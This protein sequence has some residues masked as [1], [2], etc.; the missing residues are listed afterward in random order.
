[1]LVR[2]ARPFLKQADRM[3]TALQRGAERLLALQRSDDSWYGS[4]RRYVGSSH[5]A[6][7]T[8]GVAGIGLAEAYRIT[9]DPSCL[10]GARRAASFASAHLGSGATHQAHHPRFTA[11]DLILL[12][13]LYELTGDAAYR[14]RAAEEWRNIRSYFYFATADELHRFFQKIERP[15][16]AWDLAFYLE[17]AELAGDCGWADG[18]AAV[19]A[20]TLEGNYFDPSNEYRALNVA[21]AV[22]A[23]A[24]QGYG[25][26]HRAELEALQSALMGFVDGT[27]LG[28]RV[29]DSAYAA[30]ALYAVGRLDGGW[31]PVSTR[32]RRS[33]LGDRRLPQPARQ[34]RPHGWQAGR[35]HDLAPRDGAMA[36][37]R[38]ARP[39]SPIR[40]RVIAGA[41]ASAPASWLAFSHAP[42]G[43]ISGCELV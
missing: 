31:R 40:R 32:G 17:A 9:R 35:R 26:V 37:L 25:A 2:R 22:R 36:R 39:R 5:G 34:G 21:G 4:W 3:R 14:A 38:L 13:R 8:L 1:M 42:T 41:A 6:T 7:N 19:L 12:H 27:N 33:P 30:L 11:T 24:G 18:A 23:L 43:G 16:G 10:E 15:T 29:Q 28:A 20:R